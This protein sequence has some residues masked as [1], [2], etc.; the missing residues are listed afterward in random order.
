MIF[1]K[2]KTMIKSRNLY[3]GLFME[4]LCI[5]GP[6][7]AKYHTTQ[8]NRTYG[9]TKNADAYQCKTYCKGTN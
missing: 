7:W 8:K 3:V 5:K 6:N 2:K 4:N 1:Q 9:N